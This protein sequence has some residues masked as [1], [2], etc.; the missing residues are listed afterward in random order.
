[1]AAT[2]TQT[3]RFLRKLAAGAVDDVFSQADI[4]DIFLEASENYGS[5][6]TDRLLMAAAVVEGF[7]FLLA[8]HAKLTSYT[9]NATS[10]SA[11]QVHDH[12]L[13]DQKLALEELETAL[14]ASSG[15]VIR[16]GSYG[17]RGVPPTRQEE[18][19]DA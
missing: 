11:G 15:S 7:R 18:Y 1:M 14:A 16:F 6:A 13:A 3:A 9:Q 8:D 2:A 12:L 5:A 19:P 17:G 10:E 4:D